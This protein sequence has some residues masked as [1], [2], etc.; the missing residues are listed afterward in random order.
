MSG[1]GRPGLSPPPAPIVAGVSNWRSPPPDDPIL[2]R[3]LSRKRIERGLFIAGL[4]AVIGGLITIQ[5]TTK[6]HVLAGLGGM[7]VGIISVGKAVWGR[8]ANPKVAALMDRPATI[9][10]FPVEVYYTCDRQCY[11]R[12]TGVV[13]FIGG[14]VQFQGLRSDFC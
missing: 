14:S 3:R 9:P 2:V 6:A 10:Q 5:V 8:T 11:G 1:H 4:V 13:S 7:L 12:D